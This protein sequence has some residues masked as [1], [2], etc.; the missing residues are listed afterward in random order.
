MR[1]LKRWYQAKV[2]AIK[3]QPRVLD[4]ALQ[5]Q[6]DLNLSEMPQM[7][8]AGARGHDSNFFVI[9]AEHKMP[10]GVCRIV[11]PFKKRTPPASGMPFILEAPAA[12]LSREWNAYEKGS[13]A[14]LTPH[15]VWRAEDVLMC[16]YLPFK[17]VQE[18]LEKNPDI[19]WD[20]LVK[21]AARIV[22]LH[23]AG[24]T[25]M[26]MSLANILADKELSSLTFIDFEYAPAFHV[27]PAAQRLYD[28]LRLIESAW[29]FIPE[30]WRTPDP[31]WI[32]IFTDALD[33][34]MKAVDLALLA[35][36][37]GRVWG[38]NAFRATI[39]GAMRA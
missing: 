19:A 20:L 38:D 28:H 35:P 36:A 27:S 4:V 23:R 37:L 12:R 32:G 34:D 14:G 17:P 30:G 33:A 10:V 26:D 16:E 6:R 3:L 2:A 13:A 24:I 18:M 11:N 25:H 29:K 7:K 31:R 15:P 39:Q 22:E 5:I 9:D 1:K 21:A 8:I